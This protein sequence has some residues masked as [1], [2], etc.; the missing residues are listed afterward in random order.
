MEIHET[1]WSNRRQPMHRLSFALIGILGSFCLLTG[2]AAHGETRSLAGGVD[3]AVLPGVAIFGEDELNDLEVTDQVDAFNL[4]LVMGYYLTDRHELRFVIDISD[5]EVCTFQFRVG[6]RCRYS[7]FRIYTF[8]YLYNFNF[9]ERVIPYASVG[10][11]GYTNSNG[12]E[13]DSGGAFS[14][15][16][17]AK[18]FPTDMGAYIGVDARALGLGSKQGVTA[19]GIVGLSLGWV[20]D[21]PSLLGK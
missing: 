5:T 19:N 1:S 18:Y 7:D 11:G 8:N 3:L 17:G 12:F 13:D 15:G 20:I 4:G 9:S 6:E 21:I 2:T 16:L 10:L 14:L